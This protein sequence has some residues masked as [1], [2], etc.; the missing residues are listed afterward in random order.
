LT[1]S[2]GRKTS[3]N[4]EGSDTTEECDIDA[5]RRESKELRRE[6][7]ELQDSNRS[8]ALKIRNLH[9]ANTGLKQE[10]AKTR[11]ILVTG[12]GGVGV[13]PIAEAPE[14]PRGRQAAAWPQQKYLLTGAGGVGVPPIAEAPASPRSPRG[15]QAAAWPQRY[16]DGPITVPYH[17]SGRVASMNYGFVANAA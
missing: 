16:V 2:P 9:F 14:S 8:M 7:K 17:A 3:E 13:R 10:L 6:S 11:K 4:C 12:A 15:R 1:S 5:L